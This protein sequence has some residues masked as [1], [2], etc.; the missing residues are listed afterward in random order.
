[1]EIMELMEMKSP[2]LMEKVIISYLTE[3]K[4]YV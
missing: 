4:R 2:N 1:M 3:K